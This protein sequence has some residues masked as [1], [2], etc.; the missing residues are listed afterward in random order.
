MHSVLTRGRAAGDA[1]LVLPCFYR[2]SPRHFPAAG[3][4]PTR[5]D[6]REGPV[7]QANLPAV[8]GKTRCTEWWGEEAASFGGRS[9]RIPPTEGWGWKHLH[10]LERES[11]G[12]WQEP[13]N[14]DTLVRGA[15]APLA[16]SKW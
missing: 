1:A 9:P 10:L 5:N 2:L 16:R 4:R 11:A 13:P 3:S 12:P 7:W 15:I 6:M 14:I 8:L